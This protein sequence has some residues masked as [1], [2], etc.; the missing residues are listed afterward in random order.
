MLN[1]HLEKETGAEGDH[2]PVRAVDA[3]VIL[4][5]DRLSS[6]TLLTDLV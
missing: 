5:L 2:G 3:V 4:T 6:T 1:I